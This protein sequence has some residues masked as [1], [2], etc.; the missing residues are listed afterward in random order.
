MLTSYFGP[1]QSWNESI[2]QWRVGFRMVPDGSIGFLVTRD[3]GV[4]DEM[5]RFECE[6]NASLRV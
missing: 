1:C 5:S 6:E 2:R 3:G 4:E